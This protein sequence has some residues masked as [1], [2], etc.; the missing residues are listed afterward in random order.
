MVLG[1]ACGML[2][3]NVLEVLRWTDG[4]ARWARPVSRVAH[5]SPVAA[6]A[7]ALAFVSPAASNSLL[8]D[9]HRSG[10]L[11]LRELMLANLFNSLPAYLAH[12]PTIFLL[13]WPVLGSAAVTYVG[14]TLLAAV[15]RTLLTVFLGRVLLPK[16]NF[17]VPPPE[18]SDRERMPLGK[19][20]GEAWPKAWKRFRRRLP[21][22]LFFAV[23]VYVLVILAQQWGMFQELECWLAEHLDWLTFLKPQAMGIIAMQLMAELGAALGAAGAALTDGSLTSRDVVMAM[24]VGN[25]LATPL[26]AMRHQLPVYSG[27]YRPGL[28]LLLVTANQSLRAASMILAMLLYLL[29]PA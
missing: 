11:P 2:L 21:K 20:V 12:T 16:P 22:L 13:I 17:P 25:V 14:I 3:A 28:A 4:L 8:S 19:S 24:L 27:F 9:K 10:A 7:F 6:S 15:G 29:L 26:R 1:M 18:G 23:P 5:L